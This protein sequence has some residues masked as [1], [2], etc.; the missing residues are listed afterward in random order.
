M[1]VSQEQDQ[2]RS[3]TVRSAAIERIRGQSP[4]SSRRSRGWVMA[5][6]RSS[7]QPT[8]SRCCMGLLNVLKVGPSV[9]KSHTWT[10]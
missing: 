2:P 9:Q 6:A 8:S 1:L 5:V 3:F 7:L 10:S 4:S